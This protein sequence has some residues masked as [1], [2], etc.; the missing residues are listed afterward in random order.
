MDRRVPEKNAPRGDFN[1]CADR[2]DCALR[3]IVRHLARIAAEEDYKRLLKDR[4][5]SY[6]QNEPK[7]PSS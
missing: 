5:L 2:Y 4:G 6:H 3:D 1:T 7:G